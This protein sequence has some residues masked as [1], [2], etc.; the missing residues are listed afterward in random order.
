M[1]YSVS[2]LLESVLALVF[3]ID[4]SNLSISCTV[5]LLPVGVKGDVNGD[6]N[7]SISDVTKL[8]DYLLSDNW[9]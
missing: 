8:I 6:S 4:E 7:I 1:A 3:A 9:D 2:I 5:T